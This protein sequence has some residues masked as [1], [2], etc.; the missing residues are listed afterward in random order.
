MG[1]HT[2]LRK[3][4]VAVGVLTARASERPRARELTEAFPAPIAARST[5]RGFAAA[6]PRAR[7]AAI[8]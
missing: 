5:D 1:R 7:A 8:R 3:A 4:V 2:E 6:V